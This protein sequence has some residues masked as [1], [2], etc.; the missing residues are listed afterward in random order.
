[1]KAQQLQMILPVM[2]VSPESLTEKSGE[3]FELVESRPHVHHTPWG[4]TQSFQ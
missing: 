2:R 3:E 4:R 1:L